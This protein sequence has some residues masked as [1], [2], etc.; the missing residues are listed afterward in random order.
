M[1]E[2]CDT[3]FHY[4]DC[5]SLQEPAPYY[6]RY[7]SVPTKPGCWAYTNVEIVDRVTETVIGAYQ[8]DY[9]SMYRTFHPFMLRGKWF[10]LYSKNYTATRIMSLPDCIDIGG[11]TNIASGF[12]PTD[13]FVPGLYACSILHS[14]ECPQFNNKEVDINCI[15]PPPSQYKWEF[16]DRVHGFVAGCCWGDDSSWKIQYLDLSRADE[17]IITRDDRF[18]Y[19]ELP[20]NLNLST[21]IHIYYEDGYI[22]LSIDVKKRFSIT[23]AVITGSDIQT[24]L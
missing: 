6:A 15:C 13:Y 9:S 22:D 5:D 24:A 7:V 16:P 23:G 4:L 14:A 10:A 8:R 19:I 18:G 20:E 12:C 1:T 21:A 2:I 17:G 11:E 3:G